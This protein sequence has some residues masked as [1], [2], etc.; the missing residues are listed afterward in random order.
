[1]EIR[2]DDH[3]DHLAADLH[4]LLAEEAGELGVRAEV[5]DDTVTLH[6]TVA[7]A[8]RAGELERV[9]RAALP[10]FDVDNRI[11]VVE[12]GLLPPDAEERL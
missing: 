2:G 11:D 7:T 1:M 12:D 4:E 3:P 10:G 9:V 5:Q 8:E 6:G